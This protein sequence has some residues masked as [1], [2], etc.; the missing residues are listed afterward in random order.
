MTAIPIFLTFLSLMFLDV[1]YPSTD[2]G[3]W[4]WFGLAFLAGFASIRIL[5]PV[6]DP[7][8]AQSRWLNLSSRSMFYILAF[9]MLLFLFVV[10]LIH[11]SA[12]SYQALVRTY[13]SLYGLAAVYTG[14]LRIFVWVLSVLQRI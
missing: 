12:N 1:P 11:I 4:V 9:I 10:A 13:L 6:P 7:H 14:L 2:A 8:P 3:W 5:I